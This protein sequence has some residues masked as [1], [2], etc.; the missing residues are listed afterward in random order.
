V[1]LPINEFSVLIKPRQSKI[2]TKTVHCGKTRYKTNINLE[3]SKVNK[4]NA[5]TK[6]NSA[7]VVSETS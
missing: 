5:F 6:G 4:T 1:G 3:K 2:D 7:I